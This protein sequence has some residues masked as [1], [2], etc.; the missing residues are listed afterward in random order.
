MHKQ[1]VSTKKA[2]AF[3]LATFFLGLSILSIYGNWWP[4]IMIV[5][6]ASLA[7]KQFLLKRF[8]D[9]ALSLFIFIG[10]F[11]IQTYSASSSYFLA[12]LFFTSAIFLVGK[13]YID[14]RTLP[15]DQQEE[16]LNHEIEES[17]KR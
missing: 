1:F 10:V 9:M 11:L 6:G 14:A 16:D 17:K 8:Y 7:V 13:E 15:E 12:V 4:S 3:E 2:K 5:L